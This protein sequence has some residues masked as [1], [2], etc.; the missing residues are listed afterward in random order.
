M[1]LLPPIL[2]NFQRPHQSFLLLQSSISQSCLPVLR[3]IISHEFHGVTSKK[4]HTLLFCFLYPPSALAGDAS[5][6]SQD[7]MVEVFDHTG[8]VPGYNDSWVNPFEGILYSV[9]AGEH[10]SIP[11]IPRLTFCSSHRTIGCHY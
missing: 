10:T 7:G 9:R 6:A 5:S 11:D 3:K 8:N 2:A 1:S 4:V